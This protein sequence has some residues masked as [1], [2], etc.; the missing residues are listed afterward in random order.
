MG[1]E[2]YFDYNASYN[3]PWSCYV[4][5]ITILIVIILHFN[6]HINYYK[7][8]RTT[9]TPY[10]P[11][12]ALLRLHCLIQRFNCPLER[13]LQLNN[14]TPRGRRR[15]IQTT[16]SHVAQPF[17]LQPLWNVFQYAGVSNGSATRGYVSWVWGYG[18][19]S[20]YGARPGASVLCVLILISGC[21][22]LLKVVGQYMYYGYEDMVATSALVLGPPYYAYWLCFDR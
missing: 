21:F 22:D 9:R 13:L 10:A 11:P 8:Y 18:A 5:F 16:W 20:S 15:H 19:C 2:P 4:H 6:Y 12:W 3:W 7:F 17:R 14:G 1:Q